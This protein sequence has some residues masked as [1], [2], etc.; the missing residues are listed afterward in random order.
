M[1]VDAPVADLLARADAAVTLPKLGGMARPNGVVIV[2]ERHWAFA[3][4]AGELHEGEMPARRSRAA[5]IPLVRG[6][7]QLASSMAPLVRGRGVAR[8]RERVFLLFALLLPFGFV[9]LPSRLELAAGILTT[10]LIIL[11]LFRGRTLRLHGAEHRAIAAAEAGS[12]AS[13]WA[14]ETRPT[15][16]SA[17]CGTNFAAL[18]I[19][20]T[21]VFDH[22]A[23]RFLAPTLTGALVA[24]FSIGVSMELWKAVQHPSGLLRGLLLPGLALQRVTT[25][26]PQLADTQVALRAVASVLRREL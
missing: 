2:S 6:L 12:L 23:P 5:R 1:E 20:V 22:I 14:G 7:L 24:V 26:E 8:L 10:A 15:R 25:R 17:R 21:A 3:T 13:T 4:T 11:W 9:A 19:P 18:A 16:F